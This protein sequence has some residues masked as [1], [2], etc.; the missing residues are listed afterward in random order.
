[1]TLPASAFRREHKQHRNAAN[2]RKHMS[3]P[4]CDRHSNDTVS[5]TKLQPHANTNR[6]T[7]CNVIGT[8]LSQ[9]GIY[10]LRDTGSNLTPTRT[11]KRMTTMP[12]SACKTKR[13][14]FSLI[15]S[16]K[17]HMQNQMVANNGG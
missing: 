8:A 7:Q 5:R 10:V 6:K 17:R 2:S 1:M 3:T 13:H 15:I 11:C 4:T 12:R 14:T 16:Q 9:V